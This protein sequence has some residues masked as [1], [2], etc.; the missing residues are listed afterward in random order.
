[1]AVLIESISIV[2]SV[3]TLEERYPGGLARYAE[4]CPNATFCSDERLTRIGFMAPVDASIFLRSLQDRCGLSLLNDDDGFEDIAVV[5]QNFGPTR[6]CTWLVFGRMPSGTSC[7]W[8]AGTE[9]GGLAV[10][11]TWTP[12]QG[13][14]LSF[15]PTSDMN[16]LVIWKT[17][18]L[19][20]VVDSATGEVR[21][22]GRAY[23]EP[24][25]GENLDDGALSPMKLDN[26]GS[27]RSL[28]NAHAASVETRR[29]RDVGGRERAAPGGDATEQ[30]RAELYNRIA[31]SPAAMDVSSDFRS[32]VKS[33]VDG[34]Y[35]EDTRAFVMELVDEI[36]EALASPSNVVLDLLHEEL[37][38]H[39]LA[40]G[41]VYGT[42][43]LVA[44]WSL[45]G[46]S[47]SAVSAEGRAVFRAVRAL[48]NAVR[49][50]APSE[51]TD[52]FATDAILAGEVV[53]GRIATRLMDAG[54]VAAPT[55]ASRTDIGQVVGTWM[56]LGYQDATLGGSC[57][58]AVLAGRVLACAAEA[59][60]QLAVERPQARLPGMAVAID[61]TAE[62]LGIGDPE[63]GR[64]QEAA[65]AIHHACG[66]KLLGRQTM[67]ARGTL[68]RKFD[69]NA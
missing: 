11:E 49:S 38:D 21:Y 41:L 45:V 19:D 47:K 14:S 10:P 39:E 64:I 25:T 54:S 52:S 30:R 22:I 9:P 46:A 61:Q 6:E 65:A 8:L 55:G 31:E 29:P 4:D 69:G 13:E 44:S 3:A 63:R 67:R 35:G 34:P 36:L 27:Q 40:S 68:Y 56:S 48:Q 28:R 24:R 15:V 2:V 51:V 57:S 26:L 42:I 23:D 59:F 60:A 1:M 33:L 18:Q 53:A 5:D 7:C 20:L 32:A 50:H 43:G 62:Y 17:G 66:N 58:E 12:E 16:N 37:T